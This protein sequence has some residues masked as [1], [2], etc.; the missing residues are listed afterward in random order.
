M[1]FQAVGSKE[2]QHTRFHKYVKLGRSVLLI[3]LGGSALPYFV[4]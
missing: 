4:A 1:Q 2:Q 3:L